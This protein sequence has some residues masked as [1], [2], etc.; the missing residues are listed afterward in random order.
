MFRGSIQRQAAQ[1]ANIST[2]FEQ[3]GRA[4]NYT[5]D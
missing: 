4:G 3:H 2:S 1:K 5:G